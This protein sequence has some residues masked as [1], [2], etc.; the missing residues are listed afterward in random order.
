M[1]TP[2]RNKPVPSAIDG[3]QWTVRDCPVGAGGGSDMRRA[4]M[5]APQASTPTARLIRN[6]ELIHAKITPRTDPVTAAK[7]HRAT[8][9][10]LQWSED[11]RVHL[12]Q[13]TR[14]LVDF[15][16]LPPD[17]CQSYVKNIIHSRRLIAG[18]FLAMY[19]LMVQSDRIAVAL[20]AAG[21]PP[22]DIAAIRAAVRGLIDAVYDKYRT[23]R[24]R[25]IMARPTGFA[26]LSAPLARAF[27]L[28][29]PVDAPP[30]S[31]DGANDPA[32]VNK[33]QAIRGEGQWGQLLDAVE[34]KM[35]RTIKPRR[36]L[37][38]RYT[39]TGVIPTAVHRLPVD[40]AVF[41][42]RRRVKG[43]TILCDYSGS[44]SY[45]DSD[46]ERIIQD[47]PAATIAFYAGGRRGRKPVGRIAI[48]AKNG[49]AAD[50]SAVRRA[51]PGGE[52]FIDGPALRWLAKQPAPRI[53][54]SDEGVGGVGDFGK[55][56][57]CHDECL[58]ICRAANIRIVES[59]DDLK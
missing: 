6:H 34:L 18:A 11:F 2:D 32:I 43:G 42:T 38:R 7:K 51:M 48:A 49:R 22:A 26:K 59:I 15:D 19:P 25:G 20:A 44:M 1:F 53:W 5:F 45:D 33:L 28:E 58:A 16:A 36:P 46:I 31:R 13:A 50:C 55:G 10:A 57:V 3:R 29:F 52:N 56:G 14:R 39:D 54:V 27:D 21:M 30:K 17:E 47:A 40:G 8:I 12:L 23:P 37:G 24:R 4:D 9:D 35:P 41:A